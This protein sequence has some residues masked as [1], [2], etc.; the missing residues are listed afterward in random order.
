MSPFTACIVQTTSL[1]YDKQGNLDRALRAMEAAAARGA[2]L[3]LFP[4]MFLT[5]YLIRDQ[6]AQLAEPYPNGPALTVL[7]KPRRQALQ[8]RGHDRPGRYPRRVPGQNP[9]LWRGGEDVRARHQPQ[10]L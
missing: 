1:P 10:G 8:R 7:G 4:E 9:L 6:L 3:I 2:S 5:G